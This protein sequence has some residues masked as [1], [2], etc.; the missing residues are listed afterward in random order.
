MQAGG[1]SP[2]TRIVLGGV[3]V[4]IVDTALSLIAH[5]AVVA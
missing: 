3:P 4:T 5:K 1:K 2:N